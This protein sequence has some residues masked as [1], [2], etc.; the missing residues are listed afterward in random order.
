MQRTLRFWFAD[1]RVLKRC[2]SEKGRALGGFGFI[3]PHGQDQEETRSFSSST[4]LWYTSLLSFFFYIIR[5][6]PKCC[7]DLSHPGVGRFP[8]T[9]LVR[10]NFA[11]TKQRNVVNTWDANS[12][13]PKALGRQPSGAER[14]SHPTTLPCRQLFAKAAFSSCSLPI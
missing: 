7:Q 4:N 8:I 6:V 10:R 3:A 1:G 13:G 2:F 11:R 9:S 14:C 12:A 5:N